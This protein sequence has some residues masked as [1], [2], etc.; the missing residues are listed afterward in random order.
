MPKYDVYLAA[1][2]PTAGH[3]EVEA[4]NEAK[5]KELALD[6]VGMDEV[7]WHDSDALEDVRVVEVQ[8]A[9][10]KVAGE[11]VWENNSVQFPRILAE[12]QGL[13]TFQ[14]MKELCE[15]TDLT[16]KQVE[17]LFSRA[18]Q[19][20]EDIKSDQRWERMDAEQARHDE[21]MRN[22]NKGITLEHLIEEYGP[23]KLIDRARADELCRNNEAGRVFCLHRTNDDDVLY[24]DIGYHIVD[25]DERYELA[26][27]AP[28]DLDVYDCADVDLSEVAS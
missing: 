11:D 20:W 1:V 10:K 5:A 18:I 4:E 23:I 22:S 15:L 12:L 14:Q 25:V 7:E 19:A 26:K 28:L 2:V 27:P 24:G 3:V 8:L 16:E 21:A 17:E 6:S 13:V 9:R